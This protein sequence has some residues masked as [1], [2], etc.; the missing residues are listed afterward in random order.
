VR[1]IYTL[2]RDGKSIRDIAALIDSD[3]PVRQWHR[4][5]IER[6]LQRDI[7][8]RERPGRIVDPRLWHA[9]QRA[10]PTAGVDDHS[11]DD[12]SPG[13]AETQAFCSVGGW[14]LT[15]R[16]EPATAGRFERL[17]HTVQSDGQDAVIIGTAMSPNHSILSD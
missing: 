10:L 17:R 7:Y 12:A 2:A 6:V 15:V 14:E 13:L 5:A 4:T 1:R 3:D 9:A 11:L 8:T 16:F